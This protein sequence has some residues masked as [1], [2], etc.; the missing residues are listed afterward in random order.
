ML[1]HCLSGL[2]LKTVW[3]HYR[4]KYFFKEK[5]TTP[6]PAV[7]S[8]N[9]YILNQTMS[10]Q[11]PISG[12]L[13]EVMSRFIEQGPF[14]KT[15]GI[16]VLSLDL[17]DIRIKIDMK[18]RLIGNEMQGSLHG[19][20]I[21]SVLDLAGGVTASIGMAQKLK[22]CPPNVLAKKYAKVGTID[23]RVDYLNPGRGGSFTASTELMQLGNKVAFVRMALHN[24]QQQLIAT[25]NGAYKVG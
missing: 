13:F 7:G 12:K 6:L 25:G 19:G 23:L 10:D 2:Q 20:V 8:F 14:H 5:P 22:D 21:C 15:L 16:K 17:D 4:K 3:L 9:K 11:K 18:D 24:D 1:F